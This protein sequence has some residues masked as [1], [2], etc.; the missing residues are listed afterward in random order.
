MNELIFRSN[1]GGTCVLFVCDNFPEEILRVPEKSPDG[2][3]ITLVCMRSAHVK[4]K[5]F[6]PPQ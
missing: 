1:G 6:C 5:F 2:E 4:K 3:K